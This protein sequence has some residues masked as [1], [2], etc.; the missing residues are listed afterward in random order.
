MKLS[1]AKAVV[2]GGAS[3]LGYATAERVVRA[4]GHVVLLDVNDEL[5]AASAAKLGER[6]S[7]LNTDVSNEDSVKAAI[8]H[9]KDAMGGITLAVN[10]AGVATAGRAVGRAG[11]W[12]T[13]IFNRVIQINLVGTFNVTKE[14][15]AVMNENEPDEDGERGVIVSTASIAAFEGQIGQAAYAASKGGVH[16]MMLPLAREFAAFGIRVN[17]IAPGIMLTPM[18]AGMPEEV[19]ESL[20]AQ[21]PFPRR[22]GHAGE[23]ADAVQFIYETTYVNS[24][25]IRIDGAIR[26]QAK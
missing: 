22:L 24:E 17:T 8:A 18:M 15:A 23:F 7:Y 9:A 16:A 14:A 10:C 4:G 3:G 5:G 12:P 13:E 1:A 20:A 25:T 6:A 2:T 19:Q 21:V 26:M 11:P